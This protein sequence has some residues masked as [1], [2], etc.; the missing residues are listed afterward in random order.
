[1]VFH[2][3]RKTFSTNQITVVL[4]LGNMAILKLGKRQISKLKY[5]G[6]CKRVGQKQDLV[7]T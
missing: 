1:M 2:I 6:T 5:I 3:F 7:E 4:I